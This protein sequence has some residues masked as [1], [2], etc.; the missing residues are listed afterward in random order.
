MN[1]RILLDNIQSVSTIFNSK[2][3]SISSKNFNIDCARVDILDESI[4]EINFIVSQ[5][6]DGNR[7]EGKIYTNGNLNREL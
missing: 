2:I 1:F 3:T 7:L 5:V 4:D 6:L